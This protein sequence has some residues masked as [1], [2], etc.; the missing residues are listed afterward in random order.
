MWDTHAC[1]CWGSE[2]ACQKIGKMMKLLANEAQ[3]GPKMLGWGLVPIPGLGRRGSLTGDWPCGWGLLQKG[4]G[5]EQKP[6]P[7]Y[8]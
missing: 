5:A 2:Q 6:L 3:G 8:L 1:S 4:P 7:P